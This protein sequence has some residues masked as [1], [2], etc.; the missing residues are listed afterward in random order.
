[1]IQ[2]SIRVY[3]HASSWRGGICGMEL[4]VCL[5][6]T[7]INLTHPKC[8]KEIVLFPAFATFW[9]FTVQRILKRSRNFGETMFLILNKVWVHWGLVQVDLSYWPPRWAAWLCAHLP[10]SE[11]AHLWRTV[12]CTGRSHLT[13][14]SVKVPTCGG[15]II[16]QAG[17]SPHHMHIFI[18]EGAHL[19]MTVFCTGRS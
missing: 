2:P 1:M 11:G 12:F 8:K 14:Y 10:A 19:W 15:K 6:S 5:V 3:P 17:H 9:Y 13:F 18:R 7:S 4:H 16:A